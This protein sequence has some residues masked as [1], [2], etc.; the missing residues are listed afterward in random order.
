ME[1]PPR[2]RASAPHFPRSRS[3]RE[4]CDLA[5]RAR[6][7]RHRRGGP[8]H[9]GA[10]RRDHQDHVHGPVWLRPAPV[11]DAGAV[12]G[13]GRRRRA[14]AD[15]D[16]R[17]GRSGRHVAAGRG[18]RRRPVQRLLRVV[19][20]VRPQAVQPVRDHPEP[21]AR[22]RCQLLRLQQAVR[23]GA[24]R[25]G[26]VPTGAVCRLPPGQGAAGTLRRPVPVP[27]RRAPHR[28]AG[29]AVRRRA[30]RRHAAGAGRRP[31]R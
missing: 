17:G 31:H 5:G 26:G 7:A 12:H 22:H 10:D 8:A 29:T 20:D 27:L 18:P 11:R 1:A 3:S 9:R 25:P 21:R 2:G 15:G 19:L 16:R 13:G 30:R 6:H 14:R 28:L 24:G 4:G 23:P